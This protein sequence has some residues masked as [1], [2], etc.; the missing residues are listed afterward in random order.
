MFVPFKK[1]FHNVPIFK[2][3][4]GHGTV[5]PMATS[6]TSDTLAPPKA[7]FRGA[8]IT[9]HKIFPEWE[10]VKHKIDYMA[11]AKETCPTTG[12]E[13]FQGFAYAKTAIKFGG[14]KKLFPTAHIEQMRGSFVENEKY[15]SKQGELLEFG[16]RPFQGQRRDLLALQ[17]QLKEGKRPMD[18]ADDPEYFTVVAKHHRFAEA[19]A[20][21]IRSKYIREDR[22]MPDVYVR[23]GPPGS[24]KTKW[25][26]ETFGLGGY[27]RAPD[28]NGRWFD[29]CDCDVVLFDDVE[30][31]SVPPLSLWKQL[32]DRYPIQL[33]VKGGFIW[34]KPKVIVFTSNQCI[35][36]WWPNISDINYDAVMRRVKEYK[37]IE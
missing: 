12:K 33:P 18:I 8:C 34:W 6:A 36:D 31:G 32:C 5:L 3:V 19:Y 9:E 2:T 17:V 11:Y 22:T 37:C 30:A 16:E 29:Q 14:W 24:G 23:I 20:Q 35:R 28:N 4:C 21:H 10:N 7:P 26:D 13:H 27:I 1:I 15:C 25:L